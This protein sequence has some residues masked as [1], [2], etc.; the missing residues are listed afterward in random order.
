MEL[1]SP[2]RPHFCDANDTDVEL[3]R[4]FLN[5]LDE[6]LRTC[7]LDARPTFF[8]MLRDFF[9]C[10]KDL[11]CGPRRGIPPDIRSGNPTIRQIMGHIP[12]QLWPLHI[13]EHPVSPFCA[14]LVSANQT[15]AHLT[16]VHGAVAQ[17]TGY[18]SPFHAHL[19]GLL[20]AKLKL[21][22]AVQWGC[23]CHGY[24]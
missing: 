6:I 17:S 15:E 13:F 12:V 10:L 14:D 18:Y 9:F 2:C 11:Q 16:Q 20:E 8:V 5:R 7:P 19:A 21:R 4:A 24:V 3:N 23:I 1:V 22:G